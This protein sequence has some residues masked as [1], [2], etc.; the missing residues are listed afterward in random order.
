VDPKLE[1]FKKRYPQWVQE[2][3]PEFQAGQSKKYLE[4]YPF[5]TYDDVPWTPFHGKAAGK[6]FALI[7]TGGIY[8][9]DRQVPFETESIHGDPSY[10]EIPKTVR[11]EELAIAHGHYDQSLAE[12]DL[13][14]IFP[15]YRFI[16]L[17]KEGIIGGLAQ[18]HYS[19][20]YVNDIIPLMEKSIPE[21]TRKVKAEKVNALF[22][23]PV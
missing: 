4:K 2:S 3:L 6:K 5:M 21:V 15:V 7:T 20:T 1:E 16:E 12:K 17:E 9:R 19:F 18:T 10:R 11:P 22:L 23:V 14:C 8:L 13:N